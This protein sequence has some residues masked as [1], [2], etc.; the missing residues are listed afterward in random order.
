MHA[1]CSEISFGDRNS[2]R[3]KRFLENLKDANSSP[4]YVF[5]PRTAD[6]GAFLLSSLGEI[7]RDFDFTL[8]SEGILAFLTK[9]VEDRLLLDFFVS[10]A[11]EQRL[12]IETQGVNWG[13]V[14]Y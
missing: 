1:S 5:S 14:A 8:N 6:C 13:G 10:P 9:D 7:N 3:F 4:I 11:G 12:K 2:E